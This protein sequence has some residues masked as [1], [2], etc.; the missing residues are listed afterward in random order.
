MRSHEVFSIIVLGGGP[1]G[2]FASINAAKEL[3]DRKGSV[4]LLDANIKFGRKLG[5]TGNGRCNLTNS[6]MSNDFFH[7]K[8]PRFVNGVLGRFSNFD[9]LEYFNS[10]GVEFKEEEKGRYFPVTD[11]AITI[12]DNLKDEIN[13]YGV[14]AF[15]NMRVKAVEKGND[16]FVIRT[17]AG[18]TFSGLRVIIATGGMT[19]PQLGALPDGYDIARA[20][21]HSIVDPVPSLVGFETHEKALFDLQGVQVLAAAR[22]L[23]NGKESPSVTDE[24]MFTHYGVSGPAVFYLSSFVS[25]DIEKNPAV[26]ILD[27]FPEHSSEEV[28]K[29]ILTIWESNPGRSLG[30]S[31]IGILPK[32]HVQV[33][34]RN[35]LKLDVEIPVSQV[36]KTVRQ[37]IV[38]VFKRLEIRLKQSRSFKEAQV[39]DGGVDTD[40]ID[41]RTMESLLCP[42][43]YFAG[44]VMD[45]HG[46]CGGYN[47]QFAFA[48][49]AVAGKAAAKS[50]VGKA[51]K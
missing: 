24:V 11:Q 31:L 41:P 10:L 32:K 3:A 15:T 43:L 35:I 16:C 2:M 51:K 20:F 23:Q 37:E 5:V 45:I 40:K 34:L 7:G 39:T 21:G 48:S 1:A 9:L 19:Y 29:K 8:N 30:N 28:D 50:L 42:G 27:F 13:R 12:I 44:E 18:E 4:L 38:R 46:D 17:A 6:D 47:L 26:L 22:I 49:G 25:R 33:I 36:S 14:K